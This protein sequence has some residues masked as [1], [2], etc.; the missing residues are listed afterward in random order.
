MVSAQRDGELALGAVRADSLRDALSDARDQTR[1][2]K[3]ADGR[4]SDKACVGVIGILC[5]DLL[6]LVVP[7]EFNL[8]AKP[9]E[10]VDEACLDKVNRTS[11]DTW[12]RL[13]KD[14]STLHRT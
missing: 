13:D 1:V 8:P 5:G 9:F 12:F 3:K 10:L 7:V 11:I 14:V 4:V 6:K 2:L